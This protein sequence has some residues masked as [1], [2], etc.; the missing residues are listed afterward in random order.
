MGN[1]I[2]VTNIEKMDV[3]V[4]WFLFLVSLWDNLKFVILVNGIDE[5]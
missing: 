5:I 3:R 1:L 4:C 2:Y